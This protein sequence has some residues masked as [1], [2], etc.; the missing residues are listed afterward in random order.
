MK[1]TKETLASLTTD[2]GVMSKEAMELLGVEY[3][4]TK[5]WRKRCIGREICQIW[6]NKLTGFNQPQWED[7]ETLE[8]YGRRIRG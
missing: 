8:E 6:H 3:P 2:K 4:L 7:L 1:V 5:G